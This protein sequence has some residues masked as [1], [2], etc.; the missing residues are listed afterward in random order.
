[1]SDYCR[2]C[3]HDVAKK[4]GP[5]AC[6]FNYLYWNFLITHADRLSANPRMAMP[7]RTLA[8]MEPARRAEIQAQASRFL[9]GLDRPGAAGQGELALAA[10]VR[11]TPTR[12]SRS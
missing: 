10:P 9:D 3:V 12:A 2:S 5:G 8:R 1:M 7:Y 4:N 11:R 6:P